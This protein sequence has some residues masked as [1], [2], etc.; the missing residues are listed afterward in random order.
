MCEARVELNH[1]SDL[2]IV[3]WFGFSV[4]FSCPLQVGV[5]SPRIN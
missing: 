2:G 4:S 5:L 1:R 3:S